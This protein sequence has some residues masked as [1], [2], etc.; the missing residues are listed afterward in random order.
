MK[1]QPMKKVMIK[2]MSNVDLH[3]LKSIPNDTEIDL[4]LRFDEKLVEF[5]DVLLEKKIVSLKDEFEEDDQQKYPDDEDF[6]NE[7]ND[8]DEESTSNEE[9]GSNQKQEN[10][11][12]QDAKEIFEEFLFK[13]MS[14][15]SIN[16]LH[17]ASNLDSESRRLKVVKALKN[18]KNLKKLKYLNETNTFN[19]Y[20]S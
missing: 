19:E 1:K 5:K 11:S 4:F 8:R 12:G 6:Y 14:L 15:P 18:L 17:I 7:E 3:Y 10:E 13:I 9:I 20:Q 2:D 16:D